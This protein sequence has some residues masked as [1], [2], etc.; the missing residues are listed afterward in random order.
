MLYKNWPADGW[1]WPKIMLRLVLDGLSSL[2]FLKVGQWPDIWAII[3]AHFAFYGH[4]PEL[5]RQRKSLKSQQ[6][7]E[8]SLYPNSIVW[9]YFAKGKK[10]FKEM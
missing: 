10:T 4:L 3:R 2:L 5:H 7:T 1:L 8:V 9:Q 6:T